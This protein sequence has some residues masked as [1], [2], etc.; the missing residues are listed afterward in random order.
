MDLPSKGSISGSGGSLLLGP[1]LPSQSQGFIFEGAIS[2]EFYQGLEA[3]AFTWNQ[4]CFHRVFSGGG[5]ADLLG[6]V[7]ALA[8]F[9]LRLEAAM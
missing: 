5:G 1:I 8:G 9:H 3:V 2:K 6:T 4:I 7:S